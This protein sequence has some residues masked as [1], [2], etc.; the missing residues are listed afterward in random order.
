MMMKKQISVIFSLFLLSM[1]VNAKELIS[2]ET[3]VEMWGAAI[4]VAEVLKYGAYPLLMLTG[5]QEIGKDAGECPIMFNEILDNDDYLSNSQIQR[6]NNACAPGVINYPEIDY[7]DSNTDLPSDC[8]NTLDAL[9][10][11]KSSATSATEKKLKKQFI[12]GIWSSLYMPRSTPSLFSKNAA[13][14]CSALEVKFLGAKDFEMDGFD[15]DQWQNGDLIQKRFLNVILGSGIK[16]GFEASDSCSDAYMYYQSRDNSI[17]MCRKLVGE[18]ENWPAAN[19]GATIAHE[20]RHSP[21]IFSDGYSHVDCAEGE[22][23]CDNGEFGGHGAY[24]IYFDQLIEGNKYLIRENTDSD[25]RFQLNFNNAS[26][27]T[28]VCGQRNR[29]LNSENNMFDKIDE[30]NICGGDDE[31]Q[32]EFMME[33]YGY[34]ESDFSW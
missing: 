20:V 25:V 29:I 23:V 3:E 21:F 2:R 1:N 24:V 32:Q 27:I 19:V 33:N 4:K 6:V 18:I 15:Y 7:N 34:E 8:H 10:V 12:K 31:I 26:F 17:N 22:E 9:I 30:S 28:Q 13:Q 11:W 16:I 14:S 5:C